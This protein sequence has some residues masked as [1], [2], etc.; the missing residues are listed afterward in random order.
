MSFVISCQIQQEFINSLGLSMK[1][2]IFKQLKGGPINLLIIA[3]VG[4]MLLVGLAYVVEHTRPVRRLSY[5]DFIKK[6]ELN[7]VQSVQ[8]VGPDV[9][10]TL[11]EPTATQ[12]GQGKKIYFETVIPNNPQLWQLFKEHNID[13]TV[14]YPSSDFNVWNII[15]FALFGITLVF[16]WYIFRQSR[17]TSSNVSTLFSMTKSKARM[18][19]PSQI[20]VTFSSVAG[21]VEAKEELYDI[22]DFLRNPD[23][24]KRLGARLTRGVLLVG[25]PG[26]GKTLLAKAVAGEANCPF[27]SVSGSDFIEVFA[28]IGAGRVR[29]LFKQA[30]QNAPSIVFIDEIDAIGRQRGASVSNGSNDEREQTLNQLLTE[31]D[32]FD[33]LPASVVIIAATN[34]PDVLDKAL[35]RPGRFDRR[36]EVPYPDLASRCEILNVHAQE[37][38]IDSEVN[39]SEIARCT[40][41]FTG[42]DL[43]NLIN[44][45]AINASKYNKDKVYG[46]D[47]EEARDKMMLGKQSK[48]IVLTEH[49]RT[50]IAYHEAG[51]AIVCLLLP[52]E[53][54][55]LHKVTI[56]PRGGTLGVTYTLPERDKYNRSKAEMIAQVMMALGGR[57]AEELTFNKAQT[58]GAHNDF[59]KAT[60]IVRAMVCY[61]GMSEKLGPVSYE[62]Q[63]YHYSEA[64]ARLIDE[65]VRTIIY[66]CYTKVSTLI[67]D[68]KDKLEKLA[69]ALLEKETLYA[70]EIY[71]L[72]NIEPRQDFRFQ[73]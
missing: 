6:I 23:K 47:L 2:N 64:T 50:V 4:L 19:L 48:T 54:D 26:N 52:Q 15:L 66:D 20:K 49:D 32:G 5:S 22:V 63:K 71:L 7:Q 25:E 21:A 1:K 31:M 10:G 65:E 46:H 16:I 51:H 67:S 3:C 9:T 61:L 11:L 14:A 27:F 72:L 18:F 42:A 43:A 73:V 69:R 60:E 57:V 29:D 34:R 68:H 58:A 41:G 35:L 38:K 33:T 55:P 24:Y 70:H 40:P 13:V 59:Q 12:E 56:L 36:V 44:E 8:V 53:C 37:V 39:M 62:P 17:G 28:G 30:R 45:A